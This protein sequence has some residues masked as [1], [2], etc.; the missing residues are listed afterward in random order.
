MLDA[1]AAAIAAV[2]R[3]KS[4]AS[5]PMKAPVRQL[6]VTAPQNQLDALAAAA[7]DVSAAGRVGEIALHPLPGI[8][9][10]HEVLL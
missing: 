4:Q 3:A 8:D 5:M 9:P 10:V 7:G 6:I 2:R 1:A